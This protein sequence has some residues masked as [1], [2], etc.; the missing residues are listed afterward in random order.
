M[1]IAKTQ[2]SITHY[3]VFIL[4]KIFI[5]VNKVIY[6]KLPELRRAKKRSQWEMWLR[7]PRQVCRS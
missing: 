5:Q 2:T 7:W 6:T 4:G 3:L 1:L